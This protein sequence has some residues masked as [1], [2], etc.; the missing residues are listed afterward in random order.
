[1]RNTL[2]SP[3]RVN[4]PERAI[5]ALQMGLKEHAAG[6]FDP[7]GVDPAVVVGKQG[8]DYAADVLGLADTSEGGL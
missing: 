2:L 1:M 7:L 4:S 5:Y 6:C 8:C 3:M